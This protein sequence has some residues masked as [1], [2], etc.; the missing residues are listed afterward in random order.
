MKKAGLFLAGTM[1]CAILF[2]I[3][4]G[5]GWVKFTWP[6]PQGNTTAA[7]N[8]V[9]PLMILG[10][11]EGIRKD[12]P[13]GAE[14]MDKGLVIFSHAGNSTDNDKALS[15][16][17]A[18]KY[19][20]LDETTIEITLVIFGPQ[21][22]KY[23]VEVT[24][25]NLK[26]VGEKETYALMRVN[27]FSVDFTAVGNKPRPVESKVTSPPTMKPLLTFKNHEASVEAV[28]FSPD[29]TLIASGGDD[30]V[31]IIW[32]RTTGKVRHKLGV[33]EDRKRFAG[34]ESVRSVN[35]SP[36]GSTLVT[37][38]SGGGQL[39]N[40]DTGE[41]RKYGFGGDHVAFSPDGTKLITATH[42]EIHIL[43]LVEDK[44]LFSKKTPGTIKSIAVSPDGKLIA[45]G[46]LSS[47]VRVWDATNGEQKFSY[48]DSRAQIFSVAFSPDSNILAADS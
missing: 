32:E 30:G 8:K 9:A 1:T 31:V 3:L 5:T 13:F 15:A 38:S 46:D 36:D 23:Q 42:D 43:D 40:V 20:F 47:Y 35:F 7:D 33:Q 17:I 44:K 12:A 28:A 19:K 41:R 39:W 26:L 4:W 18:G 37:G 22:E 11:W 10:K 34:S 48:K 21:V 2:G 16:M 25:K 6:V 24:D 29:G 45:S 14:F 27:E